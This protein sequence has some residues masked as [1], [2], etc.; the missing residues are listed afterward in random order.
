MTR[1]R[2]AVAE[3]MP[4]FDP[5]VAVVAQPPS[6]RP[7]PAVPASIDLMTAAQL[8]GIGRTCA[9]G[10]VRSDRWPT[11]VI[12]AGRCIRVPTQPL[13]DLLGLDAAAFHRTLMA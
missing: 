6:R 11:P 13:L 9:Y 4:M 2:N 3:T 12:R 8:L 5:P 7:A 10:L 1:S